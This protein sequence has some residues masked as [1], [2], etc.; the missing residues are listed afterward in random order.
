M[1]DGEKPKYLLKI[2]VIGPSGVGKSSLLMRYALDS[3][4]D[5]T[6]TTIGVDFKHKTL[7]VDGELVNCQIWD[8]AGQERF[9]CISKEYYRGANGCLLVYDV[10][11]Y[12][13]FSRVEHWYNELLTYCQTLSPPITILIGNKCDLKHLAQVT[14]DEATRFAKEKQMGFFET[15]A[16]I[17]SNVDEAFGS[18]VEDIV[19]EIKKK[20]MSGEASVAVPASK[21][22]TVRPKEE[23]DEEKPPTAAKDDGCC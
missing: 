23:E 3:F 2:I 15:S 16:K 19:A 7:R 9:S 1:A 8:T 6:R 17:N 11:D 10:T 20:H 5:D 18:L 21:P 4:E 13:S 12:Q 22:I 14:T